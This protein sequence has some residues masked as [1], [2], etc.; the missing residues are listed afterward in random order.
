MQKIET[1]GG[2]VSVPHFVQN[3]KGDQYEV[4]C[5]LWE[6][7]ILSRVYIKILFP[8]SSPVE[9]GWVDGRNGSKKNLQ[10]RPV[11][12]ARV[13]SEMIEFESR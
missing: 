10:S 6:K 1:Y 7:D 9:C 3:R 4:V 5:R 13:L 12:W 2:T 8:G 11:N